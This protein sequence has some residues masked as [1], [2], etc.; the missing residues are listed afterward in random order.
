[1]QKRFIAID[2]GSNAVRLSVAASLSSGEL[3]R[4]SSYRVPLRL[5]EDVFSTGSISAATERKM[6]SVFLA[7]RYLIQFFEPTAYRACATSAMREALNGD[8]ITQEILK[9]TGIRLEII[10]GKEEAQF[11]FANRAER[12]LHKG[13]SLLYVDVGGGSTEISLIV[14]GIP[15]RSESFRIGAVRYLKGK[16]EDKE[17]DRLR[18]YAKGLPVAQDTEFIGS[19]GNIEK[20]CELASGNDAFKA[21]GRKELKEVIDKLES[22]SYEER[23]RQYKLKPDRADVI[24]PAGKIYYNIMKWLDLKEIQVPKVGVSDGILRS[25]AESNHTAGEP[26]YI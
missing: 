15:L 26:R 16:V 6:V 19:G 4:E 12:I 14:R 9:K 17:W 18:E 23:I 10:S 25:L 20:L 3:V 7:F 11:L 2:L 1:M 8:Y 21:L 22:L 24:V 5:G 13:S